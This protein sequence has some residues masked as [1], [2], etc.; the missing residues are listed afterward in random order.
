MGEEDFKGR[1]REMIRSG[2]VTQNYPLRYR[3]RMGND[4]YLYLAAGSHITIVS[5][6]IKSGRT[7]YRLNPEMLPDGGVA[8][9]EMSRVTLKED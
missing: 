1:D 2:Y 9:V 8:I 3:D 7:F 5:E 4:R 6:S